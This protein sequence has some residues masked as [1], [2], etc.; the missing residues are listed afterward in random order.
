VILAPGGARYRRTRSPS[1]AIAHTPSASAEGDVDDPGRY[2]STIEFT[3]S[4][5]PAAAATSSA[6]T[7]VS[8]C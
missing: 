2:H 3:V 7:S 1:N 6:A 5:S 8:I 4:P